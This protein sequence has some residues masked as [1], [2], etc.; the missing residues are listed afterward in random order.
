MEDQSVSAS[1]MQLEV[2]NNIQNSLPKY[3]SQAYKARARM[4]TERVVF[5]NLT[6][7]EFPAIY[8]E[9]K[10]DSSVADNTLSKVLN[11]TP[12]LAKDLRIS[13]S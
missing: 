3:F 7:A 10:S 4:L 11:L 9:V 5:H 12:G 8:T 6:P 13:D 2:T 1:S